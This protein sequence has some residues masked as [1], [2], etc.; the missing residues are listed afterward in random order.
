ML[1]IL[2]ISRLKENYPGITSMR[3]HTCHHKRSPVSMWVVYSVSV[4]PQKKE[5]DTK[6]LAKNGC[7]AQTS[8]S[9]SSSGRRCPERWLSFY[10]ENVGSMAMTDIFK[11]AA[12]KIWIAQ[13][14]YQNINGRKKFRVWN[15]RGKE[16]T[17]LYG[18]QNERSAVLQICFSACF[19]QNSTQ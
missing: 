2:E 19:S 11:L 14:R 5:S 7:A 18:Q 3:N 8:V 1:S 15:F 17:V 10:S 13:V 9:L 16:K 12:E 4:P 6:C